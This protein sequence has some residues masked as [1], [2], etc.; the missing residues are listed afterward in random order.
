M[1]KVS[2]LITCQFIADVEQSLYLV[3]FALTASVAGFLNLNVWYS[4]TPV[5]YGLIVGLQIPLAVVLQYTVLADV[6]TSTGSVWEI[7]G[8][9]LVLTGVMLSPMHDL[10]LSC[11][12]DTKLVK[13]KEE[14]CIT[15]RNTINEKSP[16]A[17]DSNRNQI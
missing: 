16:L 11:V 12:E 9:A 8:C 6:M 14:Q 10:T 2:F 13:N 4:L 5:E 3:G 7:T 1:M 15:A 17:I